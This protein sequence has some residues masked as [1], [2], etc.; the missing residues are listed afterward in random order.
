MLAKPFIGKMAMFSTTKIDIL[1]EKCNIYPRENI[2]RGGG[3][4]RIAKKD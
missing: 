2:F 1:R 4:L 3:S